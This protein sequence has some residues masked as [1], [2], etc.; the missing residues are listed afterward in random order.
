MSDVAT[1]R[2]SLYALAI[3]GALLVECAQQGPPQGGPPD[4]TP[5]TVTSNLPASGA[6]SVPRD[7]S[8]TLEFSE[9]VDRTD[10]L[11][12]FDISPPRPAPRR[13]TWSMRGR[14]VELQW[15]D[16]LR[17][18]TTYRVMIATRLVDRRGNKL[19]MPYTFAFSTGGAVDRGEIRGRVYTEDEKSGAF[20]VAAY[21]LETMPDTFWLSP[22]DYKT[23]TGAGGQFDLPYL[24]AGHYRLLAFT[25][26]NRNGRLD[27]GEQ[28][29]LA[30]RDL[31]VADEAPS[32]S[33]V[34]FPVVHDTIPLSI[35]ASSVF[36][37]G[38]AAL[39]F[40]HPL[41]TTTAAS[42]RVTVMDSSSNETIANSL[43]LPT[44][45]KPSTLLVR[46]E[47]WRVG[48]TY[49]VKVGDITDI[50]G[51]MLLADS[52]FLRYVPAP[53]S[54]R[55]RLDLVSIPSRQAAT[56]PNDPIVWIFS[57]PIQTERLTDHVAVTDTSGHAIAGVAHWIDARTL[58]FDPEAPWPDTVM[59]VATLDSAS[60]LD[61]SGNVIGAGVFRWRFD[62]LSSERMGEIDGQLSGG[63]VPSVRPVWI[64]ARAIGD[65]RRSAFRAMLPGPFT[66]TLPEGKWLLGSFV[67][68]DD[69]ARWTPGSLA[70]FALPELRM[71]HPDT[72]VVRVRF[73]LE[74]VT[75]Q[76]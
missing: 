26:A 62:A 76:F 38:V 43:L 51:R 30:P 29:A 34:V 5:P 56:T 1:R 4:V 7:A 45:K 57:E 22:P 39:T 73:T 2:S 75:L 69:N 40:S 72:V 48:A 17:D 23:Q 41:D 42:W 49:H 55:P 50:R 25:D 36:V 14:R 63:G 20:D 46:S 3:L 19:A 18:S 15:S 59:V 8:I 16:S 11:Q 58:R 60:I 21:Q 12:K 53:D 61:W 44:A 66:L 13:Q 6:V 35:R 74:D 33:V 71:S 37:P 52:C 32:E 70:P 28:Y 9:P 31:R 27:Q 64:T 68:T 24:R 54:A 65:A 67:D 10:F 47:S